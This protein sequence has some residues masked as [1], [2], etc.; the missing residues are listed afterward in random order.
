MRQPLQNQ[1]L[2]AEL[3]EQVRLLARF[4][5]IGSLDGSFVTKKIGDEVYSYFQFYGGAGSTKK[6]LYLG[7]L[8]DT[9]TLIAQH[10]QEKIAAAPDQQNIL[11]L[12]AQLRAGGALAT[13]H[14]SAKVIRQLAETGVF[15]L[16]GVLVGTHAYLVLGNVLGVTWEH[17]ALRTQDVDI[18]GLAKE[19]ELA[20]VLPQ[21]QADIPAALDSLKMGFLP[22]PPFNHK[23]PS[24]TFKV[25]GSGLRLDVLTPQRGNSTAPIYIRRFN[26]G[27]QPLRFLDFLLEEPIEAVVINGGGILV[28]VPSPARYAIHKLI[29]SE[30]RDPSSQGKREKDILQAAQILS[31]LQ[32]ERPGD[33]MAAV[34]AAMAK[35]PGWSKRLNQG[36][37]SMESKYGVKVT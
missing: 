8:A 17:A 25:R 34:D 21:I 22:V 15:H 6:Q 19:S 10:Q 20:I 13:D 5:G 23:D 32:E 18:A 30:E 24:T 36:M 1:T 35:G 33:V 12:C 29:I 28:N 27:A 2:Y 4:R 26:T 3:L 11:R 37:K 14:T 16:G 7:K 31:V 9:E